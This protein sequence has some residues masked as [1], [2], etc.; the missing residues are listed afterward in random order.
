MMYSNSWTTITDG[1]IVEL[2]TKEP[3]YNPEIEKYTDYEYTTSQKVTKIT[4]DFVESAKNDFNSIN[5]TLSDV[6]TGIS[7]GAKVLK[8]L[9]YFALLGGIYYVYKKAN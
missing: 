9:P 1:Q 6:G 7:N 4:N 8:V 5:E 2:E 3:V